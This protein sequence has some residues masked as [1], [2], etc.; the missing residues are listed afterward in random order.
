MLA[1]EACSASVTYL[2]FTHDGGRIVK[3]LFYFGWVFDAMM[4]VYSLI[5]G[6]IYG[7]RFVLGVDKILKS[8]PG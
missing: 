5:I 1:L 3:G 4:F 2:L 7:Y 8:G 6:K